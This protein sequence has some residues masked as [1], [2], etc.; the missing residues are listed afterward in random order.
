[1]GLKRKRNLVNHC[2]SCKELS[3]LFP[4]TF[5]LFQFSEEISMNINF[6]HNRPWTY[7]EV[8][9]FHDMQFGADDIAPFRSAQ[10]CHFLLLR[11]VL[12]VLLQGL[13]DQN[14][15]VVAY[16]PHGKRKM[17]KC[18]MEN[19]NGSGNQSIY[20]CIYIF[21]LLKL[22]YPAGRIDDT[23]QRI[24]NQLSPKTTVWIWK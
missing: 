20:V 23:T 5:K 15:Q 17:E 4:N 22:N 8:F 13:V 21:S 3:I 1:M 16:A 12:F 24:I 10:E 7:L 14:S 11:L 9:A 6:G 18:R 19:W 2:K